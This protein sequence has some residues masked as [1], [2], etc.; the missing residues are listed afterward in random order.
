M[1]I[2]G[3]PYVLCPIFWVSKNE[4]ERGP[5]MMEGS[6]VGKVDF[7]QDF[8]IY[9]SVPRE[10]DRKCNTN[11][12]T[13]NVLGWWGLTPIWLHRLLSKISKDRLHLAVF[14]LS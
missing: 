12:A 14:V 13:N 3:H 6:V 10:V 1:F 5:S 7:K 2:V 8:L 9:S 4:L 11:G